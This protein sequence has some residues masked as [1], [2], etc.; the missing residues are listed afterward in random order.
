[1]K[2]TFFL[3]IALVAFPLTAKVDPPN[4]DFSLDTMKDFM[5]GQKLQQIQKKYGKG[6]KISEGGGGIVYRFYVTQLR[7][8][9]PVF[10]QLKGQEVGDLFTRLPTYFLH[11]TFHQSL[12]NRIGPQNQYLKRE[13]SAI[14]IWDKVSGNTH[15]YSGSC[16]ITCFPNY[17]AVYP[18]GSPAP[19]LNKFSK[20]ANFGMAKDKVETT[21]P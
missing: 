12:I 16:T 10:I 17:Y 1:M 21:A 5:P 20:M 15:V 6:T 13:N 9:F 8:K 19:L 18:A 14:Y 4:Y 7:Y 3:A 11:D 2:I